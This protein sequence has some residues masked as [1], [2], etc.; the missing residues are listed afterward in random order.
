M[1]R[2]PLRRVHGWAVEQGLLEATPDARI[3]LTIRGRL[4]SNEVFG[5]IV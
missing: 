5:R 3:V 2:P 1:T 4:L